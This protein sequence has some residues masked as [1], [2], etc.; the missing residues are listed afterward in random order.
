LNQDQPYEIET[1]SAQKAIVRFGNFVDHER[2]KLHDKQLQ[3]TVLT[4][5]HVAIDVSSS[6]FI[7]SEWIRKL[8]DLSKEAK[9]AGRVLALVGVQPSVRKSSDLL[10][11][12]KD[13]I[14]VATIDDVWKIT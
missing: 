14:F 2:S 6:E 5:N 12:S 7:G 4:H 13:F 8:Q 3:D 1:H 11:A 9:R 10:A